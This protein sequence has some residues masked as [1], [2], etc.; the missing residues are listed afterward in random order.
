[1]FCTII[2]TIFSV[3][4]STVL[5][6]P[7]VS[8]IHIVHIHCLL[9]NTLGA[10]CVL[11]VV[12]QP[13]GRL[14]EHKHDAKRE[15]N[16]DKLPIWS[17]QKHTC[18]E[19]W[20]SDAKECAR[21]SRKKPSRRGQRRE[22]TL[23]Q[24]IQ[25][26]S[27]EMVKSEP[28]TFWLVLG[29]VWTCCAGRVV[30]TELG[31]WSIKTGLNTVLQRE[32]KMKGRGGGR[33]CTWVKIKMKATQDHAECPNMTL[34]NNG[35]IITKTTHKRQQLENGMPKAEYCSFPCGSC[36]AFHAGREWRIAGR[37]GDAKRHETWHCKERSFSSQL[38]RDTQERWGKSEKVQGMRKRK[39]NR[40]T[41]KHMLCV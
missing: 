18:G 10:E 22:N 38:T 40:L 19:C 17:T 1:M 2:S 12:T 21:Q 8:C 14:W 7:R 30:A 26:A 9:G 35:S 25:S 20:K 3:I 15:G 29:A 13:G 39:Q 23:K 33:Q 6:S 24:Q 34:E 16:K 28:L 11:G 32:H 41:S 27:R 37:R 5:C 36:T 4:F 31:L